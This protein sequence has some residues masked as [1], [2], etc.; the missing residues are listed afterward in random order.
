MSGVRV[1]TPT[2]AQ[3]VEGRWSRD[4]LQIA[5]CGFNPAKYLSFLV[6]TLAS[7]Q[8]DFHTKDTQEMA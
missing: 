5:L 4:R 7:L 6:Y 2:P 8:T 3:T 1:Q